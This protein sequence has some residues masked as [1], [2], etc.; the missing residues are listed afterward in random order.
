[1]RVL[2]VFCVQKWRIFIRTHNFLGEFV[3]CCPHTQNTRKIEFNFSLRDYAVLFDDRFNCNLFIYWIYYEMVW[4]LPTFRLLFVLISLWLATKNTPQC[5]LIC[6][7]LTAPFMFFSHNI[8]II[9]EIFGVNCL[10]LCIV[11]WHCIRVACGENAEHHFTKKEHTHSNT[12]YFST[13]FQRILIYILYK[14]CCM[15][16][17]LWD[18]IYWIYFNQAEHYG[19]SHCHLLLTR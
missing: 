11:N 9:G 1:M 7:T 19:A 12:V 3:F 17:D 6:L 2:N 13:M 4:A 18:K 8:C 5:R 10:S 14:C 16:R 15:R